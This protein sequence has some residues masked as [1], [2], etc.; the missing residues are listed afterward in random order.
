MKVRR[1][2]EGDLNKLPAF[3]SEGFTS[4]PPHVWKSRFEMWW[5]DNPSMRPEIPRGWILENEEAQIVGAFCNIPVTFQINGKT[6]IAMASSSWY[7][8]PNARG[9]SLLLFR[10]FIRQD[11]GGL[12][13]NTTPIDTAQKIYAKFG[14]STINIPFNN[15]EYWYIRN[16][17]SILKVFIDKFSKSHKLFSCAW[18]LLPLLR[19][20]SPLVR[21]L[22]DNRSPQHKD[23]RYKCSVCTHCDASFTGLWERTKKNTTTLYRDAETLN[24]LFFSEA[25]AEKRYVVKCNNQKDGT[26]EGYMAFNILYPTNR[27]IKIMQLM[28]AF[29]PNP[30]KD[31][32]LTLFEFSKELA[33]KKDVAAL[34]LWSLNDEM[35]RILKSKLKIKRRCKYPYLYKLKGINVQNAKQ[36]IANNYIPSFIDP[37]RGVI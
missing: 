24:W 35:D 2:E 5:I 23:D 12:L 29:I 27:N 6:G 4:D 37:D 13:L 30:S 31:I 25:V 32:V 20:I 9:G 28:D 8:K 16:Y 36:D 18:I 10:E 21:R 11:K 7:V 33:K 26:L 34:T 14:F 19:L 15:M 1:I 17:Q 3:L 22:K